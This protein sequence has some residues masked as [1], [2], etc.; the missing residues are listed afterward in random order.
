MEKSNLFLKIFSVLVWLPPCSV[1]PSPRRVS[2]FFPPP[3]STVAGFTSSRQRLTCHMA[4]I[5]T[6]RLF[7]TLLSQHFEESVSRSS[8]GRLSVF[9]LTFKEGIRGPEFTKRHTSTSSDLC[10]CLC[11]NVLQ[12]YRWR[13]GRADVRKCGMYSGT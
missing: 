12:V 13:T 7:S 1:T 5:K 10:F 8:K 6:Q 9:S 4:H 3:C 2:P 11:Q